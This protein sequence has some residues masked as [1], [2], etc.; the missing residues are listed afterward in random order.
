MKKRFLHDMME[1]PYPF[2]TAR[3]MSHGF[4]AKS[5]IVDAYIDDF[6]DCEFHVTGGQFQ[7]VYGPN[8]PS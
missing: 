1:K 4:M 5:H 2:G 8:G 7:I 6:C 3:V